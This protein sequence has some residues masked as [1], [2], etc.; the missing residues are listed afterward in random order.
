MHTELAGL[1]VEVFQADAG[2]PSAAVVLCHGFGAP[3][4]DLVGLGPELVRLQPSLRSVRFYFPAA[5][6]DLSQLGWGAARAWW[7]IDMAAVQRL[8]HD[9]EALREFRRLEPEGMAAARRA[10]H[11]LVM[12]IADTTKLPMKRL[13]LGG[14]SQGSMIA[15]DVALRLEESPG[16]LVVLSGTLLIEDVWRAKAK[17]RAGLPVFQSHGRFDPVLPYQAAEWLRELLTEAG[18]TPE[19]A[20]FDGG[21]TI[22][23]DALLKLGEFLARQV[24]R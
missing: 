10:V 8:Q 7:M 5:P 16:A 17:A 2:P 14:F 13:V 20:P 12:Q 4:D 19:F 15:T 22:D 1:E 23:R 9:A 24:T 3:G 6:L 11:A 21:H 18:L